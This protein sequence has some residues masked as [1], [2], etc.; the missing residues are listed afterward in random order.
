MVD[1]SPP[2]MA[3]GLDRSH[4]VRFALIAIGVFLLAYNIRLVLF[5]IDAFAAFYRAYPWQ[6]GET[7]WKSIWVAL[8]I[9]GVMAA[10]RV[11]V[12]GALRELGLWGA[13]GFALGA[14]LV[15]TLP[16]AALGVVLPV[17]P[18]LTLLPIWMT[19]VVS[20]LSE[21]VL[22][23]GYLF[24]QL[25]ERAGW[26]VWVAVVMN[27]VPFAWGHIGQAAQTGMGLLG[28]VLVLLIT[29]VGAALASWLLVRW[30]YNL[31]FIIGL[32]ALVNL[33]WYVFAVD[34]TVIGGWAGNIARLLT[35]ALAILISLQRARLVAW[36]RRRSVE[37]T[38]AA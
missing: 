6:V 37:V 3:L 25:Y 4:K 21:E 12:P 35:F 34:E 14:A 20:P 18:S 9:V 32:H 17:N 27:V 22:F 16:V 8:A 30:E 23:R 11:G 31:W 19:A 10:H 7:A 15:A 2:A 13:A 1:N 28:A 26:P 29:G 38:G 36:L 5:R 24:H 33:W